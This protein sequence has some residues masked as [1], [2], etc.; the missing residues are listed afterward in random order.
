MADF[1]G[2]KPIWSTACR[3]LLANTPQKRVYGRR[4]GRP[5]NQSRKDVI[6][7]LLPQ[8]AIDEGLLK[9]DG[10]LALSSLFDEDYKECW[11]EIGFG[12]GEHLAE[13][14]RCREALRQRTRETRLS[15]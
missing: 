6:E 9:E 5:L 13:L 10:S 11:F 15:C 4:Q 12:A 7:T 1:P 8:L 14:M 2:K 3:K